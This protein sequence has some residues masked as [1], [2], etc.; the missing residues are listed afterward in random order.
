MENEEI[1]FIDYEHEDFYKKH[2]A[3]LE[4][5]GKADVYHKSAIY[6]LGICE[7]TRSNF[8]KILNLETDSTNIDS[9]QSA[10]QTG[11]SKRVTRMALNLW[12]SGNMYENRQAEKEDRVSKN[13]CV[14]ELFCDGYARYFMQAVKLRYPENFREYQNNKIILLNNDSKDSNKKYGA[15]IRIGYCQSE[16]SAMLKVEERKER[17]LKFCKDNGY[18][19]NRVYCDIGFS[20]ALENRIS[21]DKLV[22]N[23]NNGKLEGI[24]AESLSTIIREPSF[25]KTKMFLQGIKG[26]IISMQNG[27]IKDKDSKIFEIEMDKAEQE[28][29][30]QRAELSKRINAE[31]DKIANKS[32]K[33]LEEQLKKTFNQFYKQELAKRR[34]TTGEW[35]QVS[36]EQRKGR[37]DTR[38]KSKKNKNLDR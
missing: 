37:I 26:Q 13:Y 14:S 35:K 21:L 23:V 16:F 31:K 5:I 8:S 25:A 6:T 20:G 27:V 18:N 7:T 28:I 9:L 34:N 38:M 36:D 1:E 12:N 22:D 32:D 17:L 10:W 2:I 15:Y 29:E 24:I 4:K 33:P 19:V 11:T 30:Q 3:E